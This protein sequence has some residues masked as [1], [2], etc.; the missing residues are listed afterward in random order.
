[1]QSKLALVLK[2]FHPQARC[3]GLLP[4]GDKYSCYSVLQRMNTSMATVMFGPRGARGVDI[5]VPIIERVGDPSKALLSGSGN[6]K[7]PFF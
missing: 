5:P 2:E 3:N 1:M 6:A 4:H 7:S